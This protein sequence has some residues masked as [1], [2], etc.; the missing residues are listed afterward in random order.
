M[1]LFMYL[2]VCV[3]CQTFLLFIPM[4]ALYQWK[5]PVYNSPSIYTMVVSVSL[6][7]V[8]CLCALYECNPWACVTKLSKGK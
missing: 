4:V 3:F 8:V 6:H 7:F 5:E 1:T 2:W